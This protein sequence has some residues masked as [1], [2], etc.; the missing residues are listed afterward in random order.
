M[1]LFTLVFMCSGPSKG[2][3]R[4]V[5]DAAEEKVEE[6]DEDED[7]DKRDPLDVREG[8]K[9]AAEEDDEE[10]DEAPKKSPKKRTP[11]A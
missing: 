1:L 2:K 6:E 8:D 9:A 7:T 5:P 4:E 11:K 3:K 10:E